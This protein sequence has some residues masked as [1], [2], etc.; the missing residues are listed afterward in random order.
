MRLVL[1]LLI[2]IAL[3]A[4]AGEI[5]GALSQNRVSLTAN[6]SGSEILIFGAIRHDPGPAVNTRRDGLGAEI[7]NP[8]DPRGPST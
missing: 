3:P 8:A 5:V 1:A 6:Y 2:L 7:V 4:R